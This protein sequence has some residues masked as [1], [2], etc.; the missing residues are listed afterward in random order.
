MSSF[1]LTI[2]DWRVSHLAS[3]QALSEQDREM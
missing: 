3:G 2:L 1:S